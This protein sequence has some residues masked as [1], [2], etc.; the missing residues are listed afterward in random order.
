MSKLIGGNPALS[1][2][3]F[4]DFVIDSGERMT[5]NGAIQ[6]TFI[7]F[8]LL[9]IPASFLYYKIAS[10]VTVLPDGTTLFGPAVSAYTPLIWGGAIVGLIAVFVGIFKK[11]WSP[12]TA[13][14][15]SVGYGLAIG[16]ITAM[17]G[18]QFQGIVFQ[19]ICLTLGVLLI[20]LG[21]FSSNVLRATPKFTKIV[22]ALI[23]GI[24]FTYL[25]SWILGMFGITVPFLHTNSMF[26]IAF[27]AGVCIVA[28]LSLIIDFE[29][30]KQGA[31]QGAPK[32][33]EWYGAM[34]LIITLV[35]LYLNILRLLA[36]LQ[37]RD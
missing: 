5:L 11:E 32:Y 16:G 29:V 27:T 19:A 31:D 9:V 14:I 15:Y 3:K 6:K 17:Y 13:P 36:A 22:S 35:W 10:A 26:G 1:Q 21:L 8:A 25:V 30:I 33:M 23:F 20:M 28:A 34:G 24:F 4:S 37:S 2:D 18:L 12:I 7:L